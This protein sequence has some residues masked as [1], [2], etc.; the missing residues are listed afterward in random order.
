MTIRAWISA[1]IHACSRALAA[2]AALAGAAATPALAAIPE[3]DGRE[4]NICITSLYASF[5]KGADYSIFQPVAVPP[6]IRSE[7][8]AKYIPSSMAN[9]NSQGFVASQILDRSMTSIFDSKEFQETSVGKASKSVEKSMAQDVAI[10]GDDPLST[11]HIF[12]FQVK[13]ANAKAQMDYTGFFN[14][15]VSYQAASQTTNLEIFQDLSKTTKLVYDHSAN[16]VETRNMV[17]LRWGI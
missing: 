9:S 1:W 4:I 6:A 12:K 7:D 17:S 15:Q 2:A 11:K 5:G 13:A 16:P 14:A 8:V 3:R 10:S